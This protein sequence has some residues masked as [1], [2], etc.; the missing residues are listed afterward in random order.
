MGKNSTCSAEG[1]DQLVGPKGARGF[2]S[3]H[4]RHWRRE[5]GKRC[6]FT[7]CDSYAS[8]KGLCDAHRLQLRS[9]KGL[10]EKRPG[11]NKLTP[12][13]RFWRYV[14]KGESCWTWSAHATHLGYGRMIV[15]KTVKYAHRLSWEFTNGPIPEG[16]V[17]D[18]ICH[19]TS[20]VR[21]DHLRLAT[22]KQNNEYRQGAQ[23][24]N[25]G[26]GVRGVYPGRRDGTWYA[27]LKH[28]YQQIHIGTFTSVEEAEAAV[29]AKRAELFTFPEAA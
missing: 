29:K 1:C 21:P 6:D 13:E 28:N 17:I 10:R 15:G 9:G 16:A 12:E 14:Q 2:C 7:G 11:P 27:V 22:V 24:N 25:M 26:T 8:G 20:C 3:H 18:H 23:V 4:Y 5:N 19:N